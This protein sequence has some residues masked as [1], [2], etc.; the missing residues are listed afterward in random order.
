[1]KLTESQKDR[2]KKVWSIILLIAVAIYWIIFASSC[3]NRMYSQQYQISKGY[4]PTY[5][6]SYHWRKHSKHLNPESCNHFGLINK[7]K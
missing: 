2:I 3:N 6:G 1:M 5:S 4:C 7:Q